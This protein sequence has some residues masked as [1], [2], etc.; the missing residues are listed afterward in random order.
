MIGPSFALSGL[1][2]R[3]DHTTWLALVWSRPQGKIIGPKGALILVGIKAKNAS[4]WGG[5]PPT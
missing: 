3:I 2:I 4:G 5:R 1:R